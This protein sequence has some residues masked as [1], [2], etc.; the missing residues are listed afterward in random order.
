MIQQQDAP[1]ETSHFS[2]QDSLTAIHL[3]GRSDPG[4]YGE[5]APKAVQQKWVRVQSPSPMDLDDL[6]L[7]SVTNEVSLGDNLNETDQSQPTPCNS[8]E[9]SPVSQASHH[10]DDSV[11]ELGASQDELDKLDKDESTELSLESS[12]DSHVFKCQLHEKQKQVK[13]AEK[14]ARVQHLSSQLAETDHQLDLL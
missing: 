13:R 4:D 12:L 10:Q 6:N 9:S 11:V 14:Q 8:H 7:D 5:A 2:Q 1:S 3:L